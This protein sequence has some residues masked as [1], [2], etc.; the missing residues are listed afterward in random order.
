[1]RHE[2]INHPKILPERLLITVTESELF[3]MNFGKLP[4]TYLIEFV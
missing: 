4:D 3:Q 2:N 1:M